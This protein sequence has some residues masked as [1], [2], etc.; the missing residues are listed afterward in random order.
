MTKGTEP[1]STRGSVPFSADADGAAVRPQSAMR[2]CLRCIQSA[3]TAVMA[4]TIG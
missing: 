1:R 3:F 2:S 4:K